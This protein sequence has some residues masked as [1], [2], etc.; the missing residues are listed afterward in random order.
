LKVVG[1]IGFASPPGLCIRGDDGAAALQKYFSNRQSR[2]G[3]NNDDRCF[4]G[5]EDAPLQHFE[6]RRVRSV[7]R[8][9]SARMSPA[10]AGAMSPLA[11][12]HALAAALDKSTKIVGSVAAERIHTS[13]LAL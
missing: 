1:V 3:S 13:A 9:I 6:K 12:P 2:Y 11:S 8:R 4:G 7:A 10:T 5:N